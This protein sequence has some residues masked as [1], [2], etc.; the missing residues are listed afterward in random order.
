MR[1]FKFAIFTMLPFACESF[2][3]F[4]NSHVQFFL[5]FAEGD[6]CC[7]IARGDLKDV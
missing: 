7:T 4:T 3:S 5:A 2:G 6:V 1:Y